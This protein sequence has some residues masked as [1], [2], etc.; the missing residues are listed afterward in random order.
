MLDGLDIK[1]KKLE[2]KVAKMEMA[3]FP[4]SSSLHGRKPMNFDRLDPNFELSCLV[5]FLV[6]ARI[7]SVLMTLM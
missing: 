1:F 4:G 2:L 7:I 6:L 5:L 3:I